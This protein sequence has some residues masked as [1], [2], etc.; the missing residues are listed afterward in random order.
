MQSVNV[1]ATRSLFDAAQESGIEFFAHLSSVGV[2][3]QTRQRVVDEGTACAP[4]NFYEVTKRAAEDVVQAGLAGR[5]VAILRPT[6]VF[7]ASIVPAYT[8]SSVSSRLKMFV[9]GAEN[10][11]LVYV[12]DVA[13]AALFALERAPVGTTTWIVS[14][15]DEDGN[16]NSAVRRYLLSRLG[17]SRS[18]GGSAPI[19][20]PYMLR[21]I[22]HGRTNRGDIVYSSRRLL[23]AGFTFPFGLRR[24]LDAAVETF[25]RGQH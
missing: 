7:G 18:T 20:L 10:A 21:R 23:D 17:Q 5:R 1:D 4:M 22:R 12:G 9:K 16:T 15:D 14:S 25:Q 3:G 11:H 19:L 6:N 2:I 13:A 24:G 8:A